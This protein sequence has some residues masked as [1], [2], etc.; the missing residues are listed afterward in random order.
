MG[1]SSSR[2][3]G[4]MGLASGGGSQDFGLCSVSSWEPKDI[5]DQGSV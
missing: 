4:E 5:S 1:K 2:E 3:A